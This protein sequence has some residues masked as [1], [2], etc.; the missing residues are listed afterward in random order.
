M[1]KWLL[2]YVKK[3]LIFPLYSVT[4]Y[5]TRPLQVPQKF[6]GFAIGAEKETDARDQ[7]AS[8][9]RAVR[10]KSFSLEVQKKISIIFRKLKMLESSKSMLLTH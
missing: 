10:N 4:L 1:L 5:G 7:F 2:S 9:Y 3:P 8:S 6:I